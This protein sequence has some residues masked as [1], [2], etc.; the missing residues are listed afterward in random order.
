MEYTGDAERRLEH[1]QKHPNEPRQ[2]KPGE[3]IKKVDGKVQ[4]AG[5]VAVM[6]INGIT[7]KKIFDKNPDK[8]FY[9]EESFPLDWMYPHLAPHGWI[10]KINR[11]PLDKIPEEALRKDHEFWSKEVNKM[12]GPWLTNETS[13]KDVCAFAV[14]VFADRD[15]DGFKGDPDFV[16]ND[17][18]CK[19]FSKLRSS[20][21]GVYAWRINHLKPKEDKE[22]LLKEADFA[23]RQ[24]FAICPYSPEAVFRYVNL[25]INTGRLDEGLVLA[26]AASK[27][28]PTNGQLQSLRQQLQ[29]MQ[30]KKSR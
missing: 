3:N 2:I 22:T 8:E 6:A 12:V 25:L 16:Q 24:A 13:V 23:F 4:V 14:K 7:A 21:A 19:S 10:M 17:Y 29:E 20:I 18:A 11:Q 9:I 1:D 15:L 30:R 5:Q 27:I 28:D 26:N